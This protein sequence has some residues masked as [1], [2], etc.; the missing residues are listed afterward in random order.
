[1]TTL[2]HVVYI[3]DNFKTQSW[4]MRVHCITVISVS[5]TE[6]EHSVISI[7]FTTKTITR[8][9]LSCQS[10]KQFASKRRRKLYIFL[11]YAMRPYCLVQ[12]EI[13]FM[14]ISLSKNAFKVR[15]N[16][17]FYFVILIKTNI[18]CISCTMGLTNYS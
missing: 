2:L 13:F 17:C 7:T 1:M 3:G 15:V 5:G 14:R 11:Y 4:F 18:I 16:L 9:N 12:L 6:V 8:Y 10:R